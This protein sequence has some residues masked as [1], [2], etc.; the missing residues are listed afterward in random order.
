MRPR[1]HHVTKKLGLVERRPDQNELGVNRVAGSFLA[2]EGQYVKE[3][4]REC[5]TRMSELSVQDTDALL[6]R[7]GG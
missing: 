1:Q 6:N 4:K 7:P 5:A 3:P 2:F